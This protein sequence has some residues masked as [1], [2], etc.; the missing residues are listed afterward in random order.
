MTLIYGDDGCSLDE[1]SQ[2]RLFEPF[3]TTK[4][5]EGGSGLGAHIVYNLVTQRLKGSIELITKQAKSLK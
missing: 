1:E 4:R 5:G 2:A 3:Y